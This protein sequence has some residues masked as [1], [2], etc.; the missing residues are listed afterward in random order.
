M[1]HGPA[2]CCNIFL[3]SAVRMW[4]PSISRIKWR[5]YLRDHLMCHPHIFLLKRC[6]LQSL[7]K[8]WKCAHRESLVT[9][10]DVPTWDPSWAGEWAVGALSIIFLFLYGKHQ[11][12]SE[13]WSLTAELHS[14]AAKADFVGASSYSSLPEA[15]S[16]RQSWR[17]S[18]SS[19]S[20]RTLT[21]SREAQRRNLIPRH[22]HGGFPL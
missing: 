17:Y 12:R 21:N 18:I 4:T 11:G 3:H 13:E 19:H 5:G 16:W 14:G 8:G 9:C 6:E 10:G 2:I 20:P 7:I 1:L 15:V 22:A